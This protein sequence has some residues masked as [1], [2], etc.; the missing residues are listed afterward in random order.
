M[1]GFK[2]DIS[3]E[4]NQFELVFYTDNKEYFDKVQSL[5]RDCI[6]HKPTTQF[7]R[8]KAMSVEKLAEFI[9][10]NFDCDVCPAC[11]EEYCSGSKATKKWL[12]SEVEG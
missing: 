12:E 7:D 10:D 2:T 11:C 9:C 8:I 4:G 6:D 1:T 5:A 3:K